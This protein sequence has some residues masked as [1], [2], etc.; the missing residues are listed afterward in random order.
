MLRSIKTLRRNL[1][2]RCGR[3]ILHHNINKKISHCETF[4]LLQGGKESTTRLSTIFQKDGSL[5]YPDSFHSLGGRT[6]ASQGCFFVTPSNT[7]KSSVA[8]IFCICRAG[9]NR[10]LIKGFGDLYSTVELPPFV[11]FVSKAIIIDLS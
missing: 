7:K 9:R 3:I 11:N 1:T 4:L 8:G 5:Y 10:T 2:L 6:T